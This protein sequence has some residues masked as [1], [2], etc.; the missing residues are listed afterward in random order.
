MVANNTVALN[1]LFE[2]NR[3]LISMF[4]R[5]EKNI[6]VF[7]VTWNFKIGM[8][9]SIFLFCSKFLYGDDR[10]TIRTNRDIPW[11]PVKSLKRLGSGVKN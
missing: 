5:P 7:Q 9:G 10:E 2:Y 1:H 3:Y 11:N 4:V 6:C 8:V